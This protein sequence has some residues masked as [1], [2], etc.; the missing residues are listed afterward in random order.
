MVSITRKNGDDLGMG[1]VAL[2]L[3]R[4]FCIELVNTNRQA[5]TT[6]G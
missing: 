5:P 6:V 4:T 2:A 1:F 3:P